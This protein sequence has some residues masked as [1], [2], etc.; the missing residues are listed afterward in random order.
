MIGLIRSDIRRYSDGDSNL[1]VIAIKA[2]YSHPAFIGVIWYRVGH[3]L[4]LKRQNPLFYILFVINR[5]LYPI[6]RM[7]SGLELPAKTQVGPGLFVNHFGPTVI[8]GTLVAGSNLTIE[9]GVTIG[10]GPTGVPRI[11]NDVYIGTG[12][13]IINGITIGDHASIGAGAV[14]VNDVP[15]HCV[16]V[17]V[18][19]RPMKVHERW[20]GT[21]DEIAV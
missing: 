2:A 7:Y 3:T 9:Q 13:K 11:G 21:N 8:A 18:P 17:G 12:A 1:A 19:A 14:V 15:A 5:I 16:V 4:W 10:K 20:Q 6:V